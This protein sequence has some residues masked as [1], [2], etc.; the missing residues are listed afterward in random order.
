MAASISLVEARVRDAED[1]LTQMPQDQSQRPSPRVLKRLEDA[2]EALKAQYKRMNDAYEEAI[3]SPDL[4]QDKDDQIE[5]FFKKARD[6]KDQDIKASK[7]RVGTVRCRRLMVNENEALEAVADKV[8][9]D[10]DP[11][12]KDEYK[13]IGNSYKLEA[14]EDL[15]P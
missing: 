6:A 2:E 10:I 13:S 15:R 12:P 8:D 4:K 7:V 11:I 5:A 3:V 14:R 1:F 9:N